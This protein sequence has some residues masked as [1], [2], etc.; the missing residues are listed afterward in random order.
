MESSNEAAFNAGIEYLRTITTYEREISMAFLR[1]DFDLINRGLDVLYMELA[2][3]FTKE[4]I[5]EQTTK[6]DGQQNAHNRYLELINKGT[7]T[8]PKEIIQSYKD[9]FMS[10]K[11]V[12][13]SHSLRMPKKDDPAFALGKGGY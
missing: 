1:D 13:H 6:R 2:E 11:R 9:R 10:L 3:W 5:E 12:I 4:E 8:I 7:N